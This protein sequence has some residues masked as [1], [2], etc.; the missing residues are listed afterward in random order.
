MAQHHPSNHYL[1]TS[2]YLMTRAAALHFPRS[3]FADFLSGDR[4]IYGFVADVPLNPTALATLVVYVNGA[5]NLYF[6][7][8]NSYTG[9]SV[10]HPVVVQVAR[11]LVAESPRLLGEAELTQKLDLPIGRDHHIFLLAKT[12]IYRKVLNPAALAEESD[13]ARAVYALYQRLLIEL[14]QAQLKD[15]AK[16]ILN[17]PQVQPPEETPQE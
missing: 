16:G 2:S 17:A 14:Q 3:Q 5:A 4:S 1:V 9:A 13:N 6:N 7:N 10:R 15:R 12:G 11:L 8:G